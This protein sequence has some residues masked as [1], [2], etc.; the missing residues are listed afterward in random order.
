MGYLLALRGAVAFIPPTVWKGIGIAVLVVSIYLAGDVHGRRIETAKCEAAAAA[1]QKAAD[2]QDIQAA[3]ELRDQA[4]Q[5]SDSLR[6]QK[7]VDD[8]AIDALRARLASRAPNAKCQYDG[9]NADPGDAPRR[10]ARRLQ[11]SVRDPAEGASHAKPSGPT[12]LPS[13]IGR[14]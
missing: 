6:N 8:D 12:I 4:T 13:A 3:N 2:Q 5:V 7:K 14:P 11:H 9:T 1:A 10:S